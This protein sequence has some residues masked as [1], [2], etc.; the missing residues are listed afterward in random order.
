MDLLLGYNNKLNQAGRPEGLFSVFVF[1]CVMFLLIHICELLQAF[2]SL[3]E[4]LR[5]SILIEPSPRRQREQQGCFK[6]LV[7]AVSVFV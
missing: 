3:H 2:T 6:F 4:P 7:Y 5:V 1:Y